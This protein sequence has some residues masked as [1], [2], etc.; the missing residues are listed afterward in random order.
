MLLGALELLLGD[1]VGVELRQLGRQ[2]STGLLD[3]ALAGAE[4]DRHQPVVDVLLGVGADRVGESPLLTYLAEQPR[5]G[6]AAEDGVEDAERETPVVGAVDPRAAEANVVRLG[7]LPLKAAA[8]A[9]VP[10]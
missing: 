2:H 3:V 7:R 5:G 9:V 6:G 4:I 8:G 1:P 10:G